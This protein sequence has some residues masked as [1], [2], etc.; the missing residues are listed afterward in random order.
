ML[1]T[2][3]IENRVQRQ[4]K[5]FIKP[6][7][8]GGKFGG[9]REKSYLLQAEYIQCVTRKAQK[10]QKGC[11]IKVKGTQISL[12]LYSKDFGIQGLFLF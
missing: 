6:K 12:V 9:Y 2:I 8:K 5:D 11:A 4:V 10:S 3:L 7:K 1:S